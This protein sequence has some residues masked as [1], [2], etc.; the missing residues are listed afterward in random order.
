MK[1]FPYLSALEIETSS[2]CNRR[3]DTCLRNS[4]PNRECV[5]SWFEENY[6]PMEDILEIVRQTNEM[7]FDKR[8]NLS[9]YNEPL[10][11]PRLS[12]IGKEIKKFGRYTE[13]TFHSNGDMVT[14]ELAEELDGVFDFISFALYGSKEREEERYNY[15]LPLFKQT[16]L[17]FVRNIHMVTHFSPDPTLEDRIQTHINNICMEPQFRLVFNH[18]GQMLFCCEDLVNH[19]NL[20]SFPEQ[21]VKE[22]WYNVQDK[23]DILKNPGGRKLLPYCSICP[24]W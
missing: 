19:F 22:L 14:E 10:L 16:R 23:I 2:L 15:I 18:K 1:E 6:M 8:I 20:G 24:R 17:L 3:C 4:Y 12:E 21:S 7:G 13:L 11:D 9:H 5:S